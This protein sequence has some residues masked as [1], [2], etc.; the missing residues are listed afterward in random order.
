[1][2]IY[3]LDGSPEQSVFGADLATRYSDSAKNAGHDVRLVRVRDLRFDPILHAGYKEIQELEPDL[4]VQQE[5]LEW[6]EHFVLVTPVWWE[7]VPAQVKGLFDR[8][9]LPGFA[10]KMHTDDL[11]PGWD[12][13]LSGRS[14]RVIYTQTIPFWYSLLWRRDAFFQALK[15]GVLEFVGIHPVRRTALNVLNAHESTKN[16]YL[17]KVEKLGQKGV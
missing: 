1:M 13:K 4:V 5:N 17:A 3:V 16:R 11:I 7:S 12:K 10:F 2:K 8:A 14:A 9:I 15:R 6:C